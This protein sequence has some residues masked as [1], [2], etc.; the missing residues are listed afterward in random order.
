MLILGVDPAATRLAFVAHHESGWQWWKFTLGDRSSPGACY[1]AKLATREVLEDLR[2]HQD[3][4]SLAFIESPVVG[5]G[6]VKST[7]VQA[8]TSGVVQSELV[9][10]GFGVHLVPVQT[11]KKQVIGK[12]NA[13]KTEVVEWGESKGFKH[14]KAA[15]MDQD[16]VDA[17]AIATYGVGVE[18]QVQALQREMDE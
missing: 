5:R 3:A 18:S 4:V 9:E 16:V 6:G 15:K 13:T 10:A 17:T 8:F 11:W 2:G 7:V 1:R 12:G 14:L